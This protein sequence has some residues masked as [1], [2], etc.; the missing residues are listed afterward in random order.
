MYR[1]T[2][3]FSAETC[4]SCVNVLRNCN[5]TKFYTKTLKTKEKKPFGGPVEEVCR[6]LSTTDYSQLEHDEI[7][8]NISH[9]SRCAMV[10][11]S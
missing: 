5:E 7:L 8:R 10:Q 11:R 9:G 2:V 4:F 6:R 3:V 1:T